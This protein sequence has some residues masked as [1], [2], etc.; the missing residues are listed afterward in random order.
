L[1][2]AQLLRFLVAQLTVGWTERVEWKD[3]FGNAHTQNV[4]QKSLIQQLS[5]ELSAMRAAAPSDGSKNANKSSSK[6]PGNFDAVFIRDEAEEV[7]NRLSHVLAVG[8]IS[9]LHERL[10]ADIDFDLIDDFVE[11][12]KPIV[13]S[14]KMFLGYQAPKRALPDTPCEVCG[15]TLVVAEDASTD[16]FCVGYEHTGGCGK[17]YRRTEFVRLLEERQAYVDTAAALIWC[18]RPVGT[19]KR[20]ASEGRI[21]R[22]GTSRP[23][24]ARWNLRELPQAIPGEPLPPPP[25]LPSMRTRPR[26]RDN[27]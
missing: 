6:A 2:R 5:E 27:R 25:P 7:L 19:L 3:E 14:A 26:V 13:K 9:A 20:W 4:G 18:G 12:L 1:T 21:T 15:G 22:H 11:L 10:I 23:G 8:G 16:V 24:G 17:R